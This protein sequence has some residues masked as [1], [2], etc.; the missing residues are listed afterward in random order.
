M[1]RSVY[2]SQRWRELPRTECVIHV[3]LGDATGP[4]GGLIHHHHVHPDDPGSRTVQ[5]CD[6]HHPKMHAIIRGLSTQKIRRCPH[7]HV[8]PEARAACERRLNVPV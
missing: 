8:T 2:N 7:R 6:R 3:L 1:E 5:V 4:C